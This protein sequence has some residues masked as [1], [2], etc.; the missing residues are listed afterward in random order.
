MET[1]KED[2]TAQVADVGVPLV[3]GQKLLVLLCVSAPSFMINLDSN[4]V[5]ASLPSVARSLRAD[6][7]ALS[8]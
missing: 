8:G 4:I 5:A 7:T 2:S 1:S 3:G 6:F